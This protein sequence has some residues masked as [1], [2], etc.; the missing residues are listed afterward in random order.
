MQYYSGGRLDYFQVL[1][2]GNKYGK[3]Q[4]FKRQKDKFAARRDR[5]DLD[6]SQLLSNSMQNIA[7]RM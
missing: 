2:S 5:K 6:F 1:S 7:V 4:S 3:D